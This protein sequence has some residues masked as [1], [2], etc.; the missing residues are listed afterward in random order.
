[1]ITIFNIKDRRIELGMSQRELA[2][3]IGVDQTT[4][5]Y[6]ERGV[7]APTRRKMPIVADALCV[8]V[9]EL[10]DSLILNRT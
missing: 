6:W 1:M 4:V 9:A 2:E 10:L 5:S 8:S 7:T 3:K